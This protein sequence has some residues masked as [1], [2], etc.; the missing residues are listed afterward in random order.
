MGGNLPPARKTSIYVDDEVDAALQR[1]ADRDAVSKAEVIRRAL[2]TAAA[3]APQQLPVGVGCLDF[4]PVAV[5]D[6]DDELGR[7][8]F[9]T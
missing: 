3:Q 4:D 7:T 1:A 9:G 2:A 6:L 5:D 8:G